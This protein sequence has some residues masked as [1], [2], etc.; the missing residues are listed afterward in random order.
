MAVKQSD[1]ILIWITYKPYF[2]YVILPVI[3]LDFTAKWT[4]DEGSNVWHCTSKTG[5][6]N[7]FPAHYP[8]VMVKVFSLDDLVAK[9]AKPAYF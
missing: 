8:Q 5:S 4:M 7:V 1:T 9:V 6:G 2:H 3:M